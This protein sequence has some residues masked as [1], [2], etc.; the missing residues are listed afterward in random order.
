LHIAFSAKLD[1]RLSSKQHQDAF[2][3]ESSF[4]L[5]SKVSNGIHLNIEPVKL[6]VGPFITTIPAGSFKQLQGRSYTYEGVTDGVR[7]EAKIDITGTLRYRL[8]AKVSGA[9]LSGITNPTQVSLSIGGSVGL[10]SV[11]A[12]PAAHDHLANDILN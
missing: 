2:D 11:K 9:N 1:T 4:I 6:Q 7:V 3:L 10:A 12:D 8:R 5:S